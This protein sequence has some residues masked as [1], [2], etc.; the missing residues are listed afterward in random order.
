MESLGQ[1]V[2]LTSPVQFGEGNGTP[3]QY[4]CLENPMGGGAWKAAVHGVTEG[5]TQLSDFTFTLLSPIWLCVTPWTA[6]TFPCPSISSWVCS[7]SCPLIQWCQP[8]I[9]SSTPTPPPFLPALNL[10]QHQGIFQWVGSLHQVAKVLE[11]QLEHQF[12]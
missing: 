3:L 10:F 6:S 12:F 5:R 9:S 7:N 4:S 11:L 2:D 8:T 1:R